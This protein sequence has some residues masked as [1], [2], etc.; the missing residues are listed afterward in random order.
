MNDNIT[1]VFTPYEKIH[2]GSNE[3]SAKYLFH[4]WNS[5]PF[6]LGKGSVP[7]IWLY[8]YDIKERHVVPL[9][10]AN[11]SKNY[12]VEIS[13]NGVDN[14]ILVTAYIRMRREWKTILHLSYKDPETPL[15]D[16]LDFTPL[17]LNI[18]LDEEGTLHV[19]NYQLSGSVFEGSE[20][21]FEL[22]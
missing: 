19:G 17:G 2:L 16:V 18:H 11:M 10:E 22:G 20:I 8:A 1:P 7:L 9:I 12:D 15:I 5:Y 13:H 14:D 21:L 6:L 3:V 4:V